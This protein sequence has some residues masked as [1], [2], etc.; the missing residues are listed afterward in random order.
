MMEL[1]LSNG[2]N[3]EIIDDE[4]GSTPLIGASSSGM[5]NA[6]KLLISRGANVNALSKPYVSYEPPWTALQ[7]AKLT[8]K[9]QKNYA[10]IVDLLKKH[11]AK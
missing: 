9:H 10:E 3:I 7:I 4:R 8:S 5:V 1:L 6:V 2:A 11:G